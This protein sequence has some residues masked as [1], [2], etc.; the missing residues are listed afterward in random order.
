MATVQRANVVRPAK[1]REGRPNYLSFRRYAGNETHYG[2]IKLY[3]S[4]A[5]NAIGSKTG[6]QRLRF[7][8]KR[9]RPVFA[10]D[11]MHGIRGCLPH[12]VV[13]LFTIWNRDAR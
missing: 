2:A 13:F 8:L 10:C 3:E 1:N 7:S 12:M 4:R 9:L 5:A 11:N 6:A